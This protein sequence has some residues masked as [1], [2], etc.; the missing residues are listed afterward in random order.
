MRTLDI[1]G[2]KAL[3]YMP[4]TE[5][6]PF[7][8]WRGIRFTLDNSAI[9]LTQIRSLLRASVG[10][11]NLSILLPMVSDISEIISFHD[12]LETAIKQLSESGITVKRPLIG[13]MIEVPSIIE[14]MDCYHHL[15]DFVSIGS[16]DLTQY[17][18]A[19]DRGNTRVAHLYDS[20][21]PAV[22]KVIKRV[23][24]SAKPHRIKVGICGEM[25][26]DPM[27]IPLLVAMGVDTLSMSPRNI[28][29]A[30][31]LIGELDSTTTD[32]LLTAALSM[33]T[34][35]EVRSTMKAYLERIDAKGFLAR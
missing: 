9:F 32:Q 31:W 28:P 1:G 25:A 5:E 21:H 30:K 13:I 12:L 19:I 8:G 16:N 4:F 7:L 2:D 6:N 35:P 26:S 17:L 34:A 23:I 33:P 22:L 27:A 11:D 3:S 20:L 10:N 18:L 24:D 29:L 14:L 15:I